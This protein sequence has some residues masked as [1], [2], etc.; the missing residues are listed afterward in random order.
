MKAKADLKVDIALARHLSTCAFPSTIEL[1]SKRSWLALSALIV[2]VVLGTSVCSQAQTQNQAPRPARSRSEEMLDRWNDIG[3]KLIAMANDFPEEKYDFKVQKDERTFALNLLHAAAL[4]FVLIRRVSGSNLGPDFGEGDNPSRD[5]FKTKADVVKFVQEAIADGAQVIQQQG[6]AGLDNTSKFFG[7]RLAHNSSIWTVAIEHSAEHYGQLV[8][9]YRANNMVPPDSRRN[10]SQQLPAAP[11]V[12]LK[13]ADGTI[14]KATYFAA[15]NPGP[16]VLLLHQF[17]RTR[18]AWDGLANRLAA[19]GINTLAIDMRG[20]GD[21]GGVPTEKW[22]SKEQAQLRE[23]APDDVD[24]AFQYLTSQPGVERN[25]IGVGGAGNLGVP[26][27]IQAARRHPEVKS[28]VF[29][30][31]QTNPS[32]RQFMRQESQPPSLFV[33][34]EGD[35]Y[36][37]TVDLM[38]WLYSVS[39]N[40]GKKLILYSGKP[41][42]WLDFEDRRTVSATG[43]HGTDM[44]DTHP[45]LSAAVADW[46]VTTLIKTPGRAP[47]DT[48]H[49]EAFPFASTLEEIEAHGGIASVTQQL[50]QARSKDPRVQLWPWMVVNAQ[51]YDHLNDSENKFALE[52]LKLNFLAYPNSADGASSLS[53]AYL[54]V[55]E[56]DL[57]RQYANN[58]LALLDADIND[59]EG[60]SPARRKLIRDGALQNLKQLDEPAK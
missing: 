16:G 23:H 30:S 27:A 24:L 56:R 44:F 40:P 38:E 13:A 3:N 57:A 6:D 2:V 4:D 47:R 34:A 59:S 22:T 5:V 36:P 60:D 37:P 42:P 50:Q 12:D 19:A 15:A 20:L 31:G 45:D 46:F 9:Y 43:N 8:V 41:A 1:G 17:N 25:A 26:N 21:S 55:G 48:A 54:A 18:K 52:I 7:N 49:S 29:L 39:P 58:A 32:D 53:D 10:Q 35:E 11:V 28:L 33:L 51:A 14:L